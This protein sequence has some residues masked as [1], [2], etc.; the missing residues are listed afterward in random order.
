MAI[1]R[2]RIQTFWL[3]GVLLILL[4]A[5]LTQ[6]RHLD[7]LTTRVGSLTVVTDAYASEGGGG[8]TQEAAEADAVRSIANLRPDLIRPSLGASR[9]VVGV[10]QVSDSRGQII[11]ANTS[12]IAAWVMEVTAPPQAGFA[13]VNGAVILNAADGSTM[14]MSIL[15]NN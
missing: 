15:M 6:V 3:A 9:L 5:G 10:R 2:G 1:L 7:A 4:G 14:A 13:H 8:I 11:Y 12:G